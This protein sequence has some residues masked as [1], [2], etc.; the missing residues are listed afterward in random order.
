MPE[1]HHYS[2]PRPW[3]VVLCRPALAGESHLYYW[4]III[5]KVTDSAADITSCL[6]TPRG[7]QCPRQPSSVQ[8]RLEAISSVI[9][10]FPCVKKK[11]SFILFFSLYFFGGWRDSHGFWELNSY[12]FGCEP[13]L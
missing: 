11:P 7:Q 1:R 2:K 4:L 3:L 9:I 12:V 13:S 5:S 10:S 8:A 6:V